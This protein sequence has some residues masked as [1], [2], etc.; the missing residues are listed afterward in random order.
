MCFRILQ[1]YKR[2]HV[3]SNT[4]VYI[5]SSYVSRGKGAAALWMECI[6]G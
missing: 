3:E 1:V 5:H 2:S 6:W 4:Q